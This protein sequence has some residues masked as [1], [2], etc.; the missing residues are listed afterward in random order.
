MKR[1]SL[2]Q[3][4]PGRLRAKRRALQRYGA[5]N[6]FGR[7][8]ILHSRAFLLT[9]TI[10][11]KRLTEWQL[12]S[13][14]I[15]KKSIGARVASCVLADIE[16]DRTGMLWIAIFCYIY[17]VRMVN[18]RSSFA[19]TPQP[20]CYALFI[21]CFPLERRR[22]RVRATHWPETLCSVLLGFSTCF[23][24]NLIKEVN[25]TESSLPEAEIRYKCR[26]LQIMAFNSTISTFIFWPMS[27]N[28]H[29]AWTS[30]C[31]KLRLFCLRFLFNV[32]HPLH[33]NTYHFNKNWQP[34]HFSA[35]F[36]CRI[37]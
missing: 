22:S 5:A 36:T 1:C 8:S 7:I 6:L 30:L 2:R 25:L 13:F 16:L 12:L 29:P 19:F 15:D 11:A 23:I 28:F 24:S 26:Y 4:A 35:I 9:L 27:N 33:I 21:H 10:Q 18:L 32:P 31:C 20:A 34:W 37:P 17:I 14:C 3:R